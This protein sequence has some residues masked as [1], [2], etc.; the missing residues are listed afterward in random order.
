MKTIPVRAKL[1][2]LLTA[3]LVTGYSCSKAESVKK[4]HHV[5]TIQNT[6][7]LNS[8]LEASGSKLLVFDLYAD[9][10]GPCKILSPVLEQIAAEQKENA[11]FYKIDVDK[12]ADIAQA[13]QVRGIPYVVLVKEKKVLQAFVGVQP[14]D[15]YIAA[16]K[17]F[18]SNQISPSGMLKDG[19]RE[20]TST[21]PGADLTVFRGDALK[22]RFNVSPDIQK[23]SIPSL[24]LVTDSISNGFMELSFTAKDEG[25][26]DIFYTANGSNEAKGGK[27]MVSSFQS[28]KKSSSFTEVGVEK[29]AEMM[30]DSTVF[31]LDVRTP[32]EYSAGHLKNAVLIPV[33]QLASR[34]SEIEAHSNQ[35]VLVYCRS[36]NRSTV[37]SQILLKAGFSDIYNLKSGMNGWL[38]SGKPVEK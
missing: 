26:F 13:F 5:K 21:L 36:G 11:L 27:L 35:K 6:E 24:N 29:A 18:S 23:I 3:V 16:I 32:E 30:Q 7:E 33:Q 17:Q 38:N 31:I 2:G 28:G 20:I 4:E 19:Q 12:N 25:V 22:I 37:A 8:I 15:S 14:K 34:L 10:C 9:W 1:I